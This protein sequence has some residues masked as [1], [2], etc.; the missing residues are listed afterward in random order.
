MR[1]I[2][3]V[4]IRN[5]FSEIKYGDPYWLVIFITNNKWLFLLKIRRDEA[6]GLSFRILGKS[7]NSIPLF[8]KGI[9][10]KYSL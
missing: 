2:M 3:D 6:T 10:T 1:I 4:Q 8:L 9:L 5:E 7:I